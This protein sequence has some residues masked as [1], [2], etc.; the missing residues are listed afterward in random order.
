MVETLI[1]TPVPT[2]E[3]LDPLIM[4]VLL[5]GFIT[6]SVFADGHFL[7]TARC[8]N[9]NHNLVR[10]PWG[11]HKRRPFPGARLLRRE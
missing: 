3:A 1:R 11:L 7:L 9:A 10:R 8:I 2:F 4:H 6:A 5:G